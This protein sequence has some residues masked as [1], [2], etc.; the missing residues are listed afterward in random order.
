MPFFPCPVALAHEK[1]ALAGGVAEIRGETGVL[2]RDF[3]CRGPAVRVRAG[4]EGEIPGVDA[5]AR[6]VHGLSGGFLLSDVQSFPYSV[7]S[8]ADGGGRTFG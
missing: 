3:P 2:P 5:L 8:A 7:G 1:G 4:G 6:E